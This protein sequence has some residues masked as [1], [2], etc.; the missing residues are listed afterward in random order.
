LELPNPFNSGTQAQIAALGSPVGSLVLSNMGSPSR[1]NSISIILATSC[2]SSNIRLC[3]STTGSSYTAGSYTGVPSGLLMSGRALA[4][5]RRT[6]PGVFIIGVAGGSASGK[7]TVC[8]RIYQRLHDDSAVVILSQDSFYRGLTEE[9]KRRVNDKNWSVGLL[10]EA[11]ACS[12]THHVT[13]Q[14]AG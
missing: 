2:S 6:K 3:P 8:D 11:V 7:T 9:E 1:V 12:I 4:Q 5:S 13:C 10:G 14:L